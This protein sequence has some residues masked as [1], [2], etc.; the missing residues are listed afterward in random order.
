[1][2]CRPKV[3]SSVWLSSAVFAFYASSA[4]VGFSPE[5][6]DSLEN[7]SHF[8]AAA[9]L[10]PFLVRLRPSYACLLV[11]VGMASLANGLYAIRELAEFG[12]E[13][14]AAGSK[15]K[16]IPFGDISMLLAMLCI[17]GGIY[18]SSIDWR[19]SLLL[20]GAAAFGLFAGIA[21]Q[22]RGGWLFFPVGVVVCTLY[23]IRRYKGYHL[24]II[25]VM[26]AIC[27]VLLLA[28]SQTDP[29]GKRLDTTL[30]EIAL[31]F[32]KT[33]T[34]GSLSFVQ[35]RDMWR[36]ALTA[37]AEHPLLGIG[38]GRMNGYFK[39][40]HEAGLM[41]ES[42]IRQNRG[43]GH[44]HAHNDYLHVA[45]TRGLPGLISLTLMYGVPLWLSFGAARRSPNDD[46]YRAGA[47]SGVM[48]VLAYM[49][50][51]LTDSVLQ[52]KVTNG[53]FVILCCWTLAIF[54][55]GPRTRPSSGCVSPRDARTPASNPA[56]GPA[57]RR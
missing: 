25:G 14:R 22:S 19:R 29:V 52:V 50:F 47:Y 24:R 53:L 30:S 26:T 11:A 46:S 6:L 54:L 43:F 41:S 15:G 3:A 20:F 33:D 13:H 42:V 10:L 1:M 7:Y 48:L 12:L 31:T 4:I 36:A 57:S 5:A 51:S 39:E 8:L 45:A 40:A 49:I 2:R 16:A 44:T 21:S 55:A 18:W 37:F 9:F 17:L 35:R 56:S 28:L 34:A 38:L 32:G 23:L 27:M